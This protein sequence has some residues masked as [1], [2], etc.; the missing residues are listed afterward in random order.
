MSSKVVIVDY[1][2]G[3]LNSVK[4]SMDRMRVNA[5]VSSNHRDIVNS[6]KI[7]LPGVGHFGRAMFNLKELN[8]LEALN[9][10]VLEKQKLI[11]GIC[12]GMELMAKRSEE[13]DAEGLGW[14]N[15]ENIAFNISDKNLYKVPHMGWNNITI[16]KNSRLMK[17]IGELAEFYFVHSYHLK[18]NDE[19]DLL[20]ETNYEVNF[21]SAIEKG[22]I[23]G[24]QYHPE[25]SH[26]AGEQL[27]KNFI[28]M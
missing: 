1:G 2:T 21:P 16:K 24:V 20:N 28:E 3:N 17:N 8:L 11:L 14:F 26:D 12:L 15:A 18:I 6:D 9:E 22:N 23:F 27:L 7:I 13:G 4:R 5:V 19:S 10:A 25:K